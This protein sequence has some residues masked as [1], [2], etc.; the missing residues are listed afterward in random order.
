MNSA[1]RKVD[2]RKKIEVSGFRMESK[3]TKT[4]QLIRSET[5]LTELMETVCKSMD[6]YA[7]ARWKESRKL[8]I[9]K[10]VLESGGMN[11]DMSAVDFVQD[12]DLNKSLEHF[13][14]IAIVASELQCW[15]LT[16]L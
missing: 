6:D 10:M 13:V 2:P 4:V 7:K 8:T 11:P 16:Q 1:I 12:G 5:Y 15:R 14:S 3:E 9:L